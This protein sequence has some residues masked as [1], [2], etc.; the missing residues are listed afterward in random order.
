MRSQCGTTPG[1]VSLI[2]P[3]WEEF[4]L[5]SIHVVCSELQTID[6][7][8]MLTVKMEHFPVGLGIIYH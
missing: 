1:K 8:A 7:I 2:E 5:W 6:K 4:I 3:L